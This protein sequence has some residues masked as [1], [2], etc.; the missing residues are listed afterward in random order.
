[1]F[2]PEARR[3]RVISALMASGMVLLLTGLWFVQI[4]S[5]KQKEL[6]LVR[7]SSRTVVVPAVRGRILDRAG[8]VLA[9]SRPQ[10]NAVV[11]LED[12]RQQFEFEF[13]NH[14]KKDY[15]RQHSGA[16]RLPP[17]LAKQ[18]RLEAD[19]NV[20]SNITFQAAAVL[21]QP[22]GVFEAAKF[23]HI[24]TNYTYVPFQILTNLNPSQ[25][26][27]FSEQLTG[28]V[29]M[30]LDTQPMRSY[31]QK[32][33]AA[34]LLGYVQ[35][36]GEII[37]YLPPQFTGITG[38]EKA[39]DDLLHGQP[40]SNSVVVNFQ[41]YR[42]HEEVISPAIPGSDLYLTID[43]DI[44]Q[45]AEI[46]LRGLRGAAVVMDVR[47]GDIL[48]MASAPAFEPGE[49]VSGISTARWEQ[50]NDPKL[51]PLVN[52]ATSFDTYAPG[53][54][55]KIITAIAC[56]ESGVLDPEE[57]FHS[58]GIFEE[59]GFR[60][61]DTAPPGDYN[62]VSAFYHSSNTYFCHY[63]MKA[64][65][66]KLFEVAKRFHLGEKTDFVTREEKAGFVPSPDEAGKPA[67]RSSTPYV[68][69]GQEITVT[70][71][72]M[73]VMIAAIAN[74][75]TIFWPRL[76]SHACVPGTA[77]ARE[78]FPEGR[79]RDHVS[80]NPQHLQILRQA[81]LQDTEHPGANAYGAFHDPTH[82][83]SN[84]HVAGKTGT[85]QVN[86]PDLDY[87]RVVWFDSYGPYEDPRYAV[88]V[89]VVNGGSGGE[90][91][92]PRAR[93]IYQALLKRE[94]GG[95]GKSAPATRT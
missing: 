71:L 42:Q 59:Q 44:Q 94:L 52:H 27:I 8:R 21:R 51:K 86:S 25:V 58:P 33:T 80:L 1:M 77:S 89:M 78:L 72:Q 66:R 47:T 70:P 83:L 90:T 31:P 34:H 95:A 10:Y 12:L 17:G 28:Q 41:G 16:T 23:R 38:V 43:L 48:A 62:F 69:I 84:F 79:V 92:A 64:G 65:L 6:D 36:T 22:P 75:G 4:V 93:Q 26:A 46:A 54:A 74:G 11:Y 49:F 37:K 91:C 50:L 7:Q 39:F 87:R 61:E 24:Y 60:I 40:G 57:I 5:G 14:L 32:E 55:F 73:T 35:R 81:M 67:F 30:E 20:V 82:P 13:T 29:G 18:Y 15:L 9:D 3:L 76:V 63:G 2:K 88:V 53:S 56:L 19:Y 68:A 85:A 45:A